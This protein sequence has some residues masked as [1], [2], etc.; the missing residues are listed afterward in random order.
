[1]SAHRQKKE[2]C[3]AVLFLKGQKVYVFRFGTMSRLQRLAHRGKDE[4]PE[5]Q[6]AASV[7]FPIPSYL[8]KR[9]RFSL[10]IITFS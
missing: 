1:M 10:L 9:L 3:N 7:D 8:A 2:Q 6:K 4:I 5:S